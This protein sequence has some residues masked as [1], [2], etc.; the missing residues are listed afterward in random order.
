MTD[1]FPLTPGVSVK[2]FDNFPYANTTM[3]RRFRLPDRPVY[4]TWREMSDV[5]PNA[6][7]VSIRTS[8]NDVDAEMSTLDTTTTAAGEIRTLGPVLAKYIEAYLTSVTAGSGHTLTV[9]IEVA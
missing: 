5:A 3:G 2:S 9:E 8:M 6:I 4:I 7:S 1:P